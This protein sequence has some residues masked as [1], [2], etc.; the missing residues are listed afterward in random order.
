M[1]ASYS[2]LNNSA[3]QASP[4]RHASSA[5]AKQ[6]QLQLHQHDFRLNSEFSHAAHAA[7]LASV[8]QPVHST[9]LP[10]SACPTP[11]DSSALLQPSFSIENSPLTPAAGRPCSVPGRQ[12]QQPQ[13]QGGGQQA[14]QL[15]G[16]TS[17]LIKSKWIG[18]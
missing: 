7:V 18:A 8:Q 16:L 13:C 12:K 2:A 9:G 14:W 4:A 6:L 3:R 15:R 11:S 10:S 17:K 5:S 1:Q